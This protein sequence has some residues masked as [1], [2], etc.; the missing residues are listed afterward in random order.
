MYLNNLISEPPETIYINVEQPKHH[1]RNKADLTQ[2]GIDRAFQNKSRISNEI[3]ECN[4]IKVCVVHGQRTDHLGV[5]EIKGPN[6][7]KMQVTD[8][9]RTLVDIAVRPIYAG[10]TNEVLKAYRQAKDLVSI[11]KL[12]ETL[13][14]MDYVY[15]YHQA[16][17]FYLEKTGVYDEDEIQTLREIPM[18]FD[19]YLDYKMKEPEYSETWKIYYPKDLLSNEI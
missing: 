16:I 1:I 13:R 6:N 10:G 18:N 19:F 12:V 2:A 4:E 8:V 11:E 9:E 3:A 15:P 7:E 5:M 17:G 14:Q